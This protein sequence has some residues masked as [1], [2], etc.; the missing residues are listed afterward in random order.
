MVIEKYGA[1]CE[2]LNLLLRLHCYFCSAHYYTL[3]VSSNT[4]RADN[5]SYCVVARRIPS[6]VL[7]VHW[8]SRPYCE[9]AFQ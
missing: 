6:R 1:L 2:S 8:P 5:T 4:M 9:K 3:H 7:A